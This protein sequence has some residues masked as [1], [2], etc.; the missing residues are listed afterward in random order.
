MATLDRTAYPRFK[1]TYSARELSEIYTPTPEEIRFATTT[2][3]SDALRF[4]LLVLLKCFQRL[5]YFP[6]LDEIPEVLVTHLRS[7]LGLIPDQAPFGYD[8]LRTLYRHHKLIREYLDVTSYGKA[9]RHQAALAIREA[10][11]RMDRP[12]DLINV[13]IEMLVKERFELPA[14][15]T[16]DT[17]VSRVRA[18]VNTAFF[19][20]VDERLTDEE[21][22]RL[23]MLL[24]V[25]AASAGKSGHARL[26]ARPANVTTTHL[27][28]WEHHLR[29]L[30]S[31]GDPER[32]LVGIPPTKLTHWAAEARALDAPTTAAFAPLKRQ[33]VLLCLV[34]EEQRAARDALV[35]MFLKAIAALHDRGKDALEALRK[36]QRQTVETLLTALS[37]IART[38]LEETDDARFGELVRTFLE[39]AGGAE[40]VHER[41]QAIMEYNDNNYLPLLP[42][43]YPSV[44]GTLLAVLRT[45]TIHAAS[46]D[47]SVEQAL[48]FVLEHTRR[49]GTTL[50]AGISLSFAS[51]AW[52]RLIVVRKG[53]E[54]VCDRRALEVCVFSYVA[55]ELKTGDLWVEGAGEFADLRAQLLPPEEYQPKL[56]EFCQQA[57]IPATARDLVEHLKTLLTETAASVDQGYPANG[58]LTIT[59]EGAVILKRVRRK[60]V[61][62]SALAL[63]AALLEEM[64]VRTVLE[65]LRNV[66]HWTNFAQFFGPLSGSEPKLD[67]PIPKYL[68]TVFGYGTN[69]GPAELSRHVRGGISAQ[70]FGRINAR[71]VSTEGLDR[72]SRLIIDI[73]HACELPHSWGDEQVASADGTMQELHEGNLMTEYHV[74]YGRFG[75]IAFHYVSSLYIALLSHFIPASAWEGIYLID[76]YL[77]NQSLIQPTTLHTDTQGQSAPIF[78]MAYLLGIN[79][80]PRIRNW[81]GITLYRPMR[82][83]TYENIDSLFTGIVEWDFMER[84]WEDAMQA[85][86]S[87]KEGRILPSTLLRKL[88]NYSRKNKLYQI[89][90]AVGDVVRTMFLLKYISSLE[91]REVITQETNKVEAYNGFCAWVAFGGDHVL[92][93]MD[94][95]TFEKRVKYTDLVANALI[96]HNVVD[97][98]VALETLQRRGYVVTQETVAHLSPYLTRNWKRFGEFA[99]DMEQVPP[100]LTSLVRLFAGALPEGPGKK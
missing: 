77:H 70:T 54:V 56:A 49:R 92:T 82:D 27:R 50:P 95:D 57:G 41:C 98:S 59:P 38:H 31:L 87:I 76:A 62:Q 1:R 22:A 7:C 88:S 81:K 12:A 42:R 43:F 5:G 55:T 53:D 34:Q 32:V 3:R 93:G 96:L 30:L 86:I 66:Q 10:A 73:Y 79:L 15:S 21:R 45:L 25:T 83:T 67:D 20:R 48:L 100:P 37:G 13:A 14:F 52:Q 63:E 75:G 11:H 8:T 46:Q 71:H 80:M 6:A 60:E 17:L 74:R 2:A 36:S 44:R 24:L 29:W 58:H 16:L 35:T 33:T 40:T 39:E 94:A 89:F 51:D 69:M 23:D 68:L 18:L 97:M 91:I 65:A 4:N 61:P 28:D 90:K 85:M 72:G 9:A 19:R 47:D 78:G 84:H 99:I 64:P 26:K